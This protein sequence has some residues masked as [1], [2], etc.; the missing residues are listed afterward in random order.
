[1]MASHSIMEFCTKDGIFYT[2]LVAW[3]PEYE[4]KYGDVVRDQPPAPQFLVLDKLQNH[5]KKMNN[6]YCL[7]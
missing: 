2:N 6:N 7:E 1:M 3:T 5:H 4:N